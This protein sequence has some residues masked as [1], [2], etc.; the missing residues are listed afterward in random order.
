MKTAQKAEL[1]DFQTPVSLARA[2]S[3]LLER[4][5][6]APAAVVEPTCGTGSFLLAALEQFP[7]I[8]KG[9]GL[10]INPSHIA[11]ARSALS[12]QCA[13]AKV[14]I[15]RGDFFR[16]DW[17]SLLGTLPDPLLVVGNPPWVTN[18]ELSSLGSSN[19][20]TKSNFQRH[21]GLD[22]IT[23]KSNFDISEWMLIHL[24]EW[25]SGREATLAMLCKTTV[26]RKALLHAWKNG[27]PIERSSIYAID[28]EASFGAAVD[29][30]LLVCKVSPSG[31]D[32]DCSVYGQLHARSKDATFGYRDGRLVANVD[33]YQ[34][35]RH[36]LG[37]TPIRW[38][39]G[40]KHDCAKVM[41]FS[42]EGTVYRNGFGEVVEL[43]DEYLYPMLK[44]SQLANGKTEKPSRW[45]LV[46]QRAVG[47]DT[48][49]IKSSSPKTWAYLERH[50]DKL[51]RRASSIYRNRPRFSV[52]GVG[53]YSFTAAKV[54]VSALY[55]K[56][57]FT[58]V[59][60]AFQKP[61]V[62]DDTCYFLPC[63]AMGDAR[64]VASVLNSDIARDF[65]SA[66]I[67]W[68]AKRPITIDILGRLD[69]LALAGE[70]GP[71]DTMRRYLSS[72]PDA[73]CV[74]AAE[75]PIQKS[76]FPTSL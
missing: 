4:E 75:T 20:P 6:L 5:G 25:I 45:M 16:T 61:I 70:L 59:G 50:A 53:P 58:E 55:K 49:A 65:F 38:R 43:E 72:R 67:F 14:E 1:G 7:G 60:T 10:E 44:G 54:A 11:A 51:D 64:Y 47:E 21:A 32:H 34:R 31:Q 24:L 18:A 71:Q 73:P 28:A 17:P 35:W 23:G 62:L 74:R 46:T 63:G 39:S 8:T 68:D 29:A 76:L 26:A 41:Q 36:L 40:I 30:C 48:T 15:I 27:L 56:L 69:L 37:T 2:I 19:L 33:A 66:F 12:T 13:A 22:A 52:F 42:K 9:L 57:H 3:K